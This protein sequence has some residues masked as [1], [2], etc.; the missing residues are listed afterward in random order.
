MPASMHKIHLETNA[1]FGVD[2]SSAL[3]A[4][5][6]R[7]G[8][9]RPLVLV[10]AAVQ[11]QPA[12]TQLIEL[13]VREELA[14]VA[15]Q[16][17][18]ANREPTYAYLD[19]VAAIVRRATFDV[20]IG[21][22]GGSALDLAKGVAILAT[23]PGSGIDYRGMDKVKQPGKPCVVIPTTA[24]TGTE[25]T[26]TASF[27]D[28]HDQVKLGINGRFVASTF[29]VLDPK[30]VQLCPR[31]VTIASGLD[32]LVH[33]VE[34]VTTKTSTPTASLL[35]AEA[36]RLMFAGLPGSVSNPDDLQGRADCL[37]GSHYAGLAMWNASGGPASGVSYPLGVHWHV[38]HG[39][40]GGILLP[41]VI[42]INI[43]AGYSAGY[44]RIYRAMAGDAALGK[45]ESE[46]AKGF[47]G[48]MWALF[49]RI[50]APRT[51]SEFGVNADDKNKLKALTMSQRKLNLDLNP[52]PFDEPQLSVLLDGALG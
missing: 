51:F 37:L 6:K 2:A 30:F 12:F 31:S 24:G 52:V 21:I 19:E 28:E 38:P 36:V 5:L 35:G 32:A 41:H 16:A 11:P 18:S 44:A 23:N 47:A 15:I 25:A 8:L 39:W 10:D 22:G 34:A 43:A 50:G 45:S 48:A 20:L 4:M 29:A 27:I 49:D 33:A 14:P 42:E 9:S 17:C 26:G 3:P 40:A 13:L 1:A 46:C 7:L